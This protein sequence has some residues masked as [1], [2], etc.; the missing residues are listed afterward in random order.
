MVMARPPEPPGRPLQGSE[1]GNQ[2]AITLVLAEDQALIREGLR[3]LLAQSPG[4]DVVGEAANGHE[5]VRLAV[6]L[7]PDVVLM[8]LGMPE[9]NGIDATIRVRA[10]AP[11]T[12]ILIVTRHDTPVIARRAV[13]AGA[14][15][16][17]HKDESGPALALAVRAVAA[18]GTSYG[19][20]ERHLTSAVP[21]DDAADGQALAGLTPRQREVLG[22]ISHGRSTR[23]IA[24]DLHLSIHTVVTHRTELMRRLGVHNVAGLVRF[25]MRTGDLTLC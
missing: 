5:A 23:E 21:S 14:H 13:A 6:A 25:A 2:M 11:R 22:H 10:E 3:A 19:V 20:V 8:D 9:L 12:R 24:H 17:V 1:V 15:G 16:Y 7:R 4:F 18:G